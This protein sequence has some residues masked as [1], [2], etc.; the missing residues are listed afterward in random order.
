MG[1]ADALAAEDDKR[2]G[3]KL[4][5]DMAEALVNRGVVPEDLGRLARAR[6]NSSDYQAMIKN[7]DNEAEIHDLRSIK[8][9]A[10]WYED[11]R[12]PVVQ[13]AAPV[14]LT[15]PKP[16]TANGTR[17]TVVLPDQQYGFRRIDGDLIPCHDREAITAALH[18]TKAIKPDRIVNL[19]DFIDLPEWSS[20]FI[21]TPELAETTQPA[22]DEGHRDLVR[23]LEIC[24]DV[25][26]LEGNHDDRLGI[27]VTANAKAALRLRQA[28]S[29][30]DDWPVLSMPHLLRLDELGVT[31]HDGYPA[32]RTKIAHGTDEL[33]PLFAIHGELL[34]M[35]KLAKT[36]RQSY[37]QGHIHRRSFH[38]E[39]YEVDGRPIV[40]QAI[41]PGCLCRIDGVVP[42]TKSA[43]TRKRPLTRWENWQ[44]GMAVIT[45]YDDGDWSAEVI[46]IHR[47]RALWRDKAFDAA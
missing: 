24:G 11:P 5:V 36:A 42:S 28:A 39:T 7:A 38:T 6:I 40:V 47:G 45:E 3:N 34:D 33:T 43:K 32:N 1:L 18:V 8:L 22:I 25:D 46:P 16:R 2:V 21:V 31:Y 44:Q 12:W 17:R 15:R 37:I 14:K 35:M 20:K 4:I 26:V 41:T 19:G 30:P 29:T 23:Q 27:S 9:S 13:Q 10:D